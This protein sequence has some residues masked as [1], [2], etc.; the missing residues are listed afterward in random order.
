MYIYYHTVTLSH[1]KKPLLNVEFSLSLYLSK[2]VNR[3]YMAKQGVSE[4]ECGDL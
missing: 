4:R 1:R 3:G 2:S